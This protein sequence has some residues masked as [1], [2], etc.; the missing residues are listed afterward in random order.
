MIRKLRILL[1]I[2]ILT[3]SFEV[4]A[5]AIFKI[6]CNSK[7]INNDDQITCYGKINH[8]QV[9]ID[10]I[11]LSYETN[12]DIAFFPIDGFILNTTDNNI[13]IHS[14]KT[15]YDEIMNSTKLFTFTLKS[16]SSCNSEEDLIFKNILINKSE[17]IASVKTTFNI[18]QEEIVKSNISTLDKIII[19]GKEISD[20]KKDIFIYKDIKVDK[21]VIFIDAVRTSEYSSATGLGNV[22]VPYGE[23]IEKHILVT[24]E[25]KSTSTYK[26]F[27]TNTKLSEINE[28]MEPEI[29]TIKDVLSNDNTLSNLELYNDSKKLDFK[30]KKDISN[31]EIKITDKVNLLKIKA[32]LNNSKA[33]F[34]KD[35]G[36]RDIKLSYG[37]TTIV[38]KIKAENKEIK[39]YQLTIDYIDT[40]DSD[41]TLSS[42]IV[43]DYEV[44]LNKLIIH[45]P[46]E[47]ERTIIKATS[48]SNKAIIYY[49]N[50]DLIVGS[51]QT[52]IMVLSEN[53]LLK[54][55][56]ITIIRDDKK[57]EKTNNKIIII[58]GVITIIIIIYLIKRLIK[59]CNS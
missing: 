22:I 12:L 29:V 48:T 23:T 31:Y 45:V 37:I 56:E 30:F 28:T 47:I 8:E 32:K 42:L 14:N 19:D 11:D 7:E 54:E 52:K 13:S 59:K 36:P 49:Q 58:F 15:L 6:S 38:I 41:N 27:I 39:T 57:E 3:F 25:D 5:E 20:F 51:N 34:V 26:L 21:K 10:D 17:A 1:V 33:S 16:N 40:R 43:N 50:I 4:K 35:Y 2:I 24:A 53:D 44:D 46:Y 55:Y 18:N 9:S